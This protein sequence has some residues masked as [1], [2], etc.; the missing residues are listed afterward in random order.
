MKTNASFFFLLL[1]IVNVFLV[2]KIFDA[3]SGLPAY[4]ELQS[5]ISV[6]QDKLDEMDMRNRQLSAEI[7][8]FKKDDKY[9]ARLVKRELF[10]VADNELMYILK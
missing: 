9:V 7:R 6:A 8:T 2:Y 3:E 1:T 4:R 5:K 10:Y